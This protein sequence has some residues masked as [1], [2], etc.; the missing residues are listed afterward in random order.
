MRYLERKV[1][2]NFGDS[3]HESV[4]TGISSMPTE[5]ILLRSA[6]P[7]PR[8]MSRM[9]IR[10]KLQRPLCRLPARH[11]RKGKRQQQRPR[12]ALDQARAWRQKAEVR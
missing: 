11:K 5:S 6:H 3:L 8:G 9:A 12:L 1:R 2:L 10:L 7:C 4:I